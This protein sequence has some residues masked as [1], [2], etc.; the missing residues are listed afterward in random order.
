MPTFEASVSVPAETQ[1]VTVPAET[2]TVPERTETITVPSESIT[3]PERSETVT[4]AAKTLLTTVDINMSNLK[5]LLKLAG[6]PDAQLDLGQAIAI[7]ESSGGKDATGSWAYSDAVGDLS[8]IS[9]KWGP[10][11]GLF[12]V[13]SLRHPPSFGGVDIWRWAWPLR[14]PFYNAQA[15]LAITKGGTDFSAWSVYTSGSYKQYLGLDPVIR[16]GHS[17]AGSWYK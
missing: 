17:A 9:E 15:A 5:T 7:A 4:T 13:R 16:T 8:L 1:T 10:S 12:Q 3:V 2:V 6:W 11:I 14:N